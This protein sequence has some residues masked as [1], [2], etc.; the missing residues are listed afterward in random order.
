MLAVS[1]L[2]LNKTLANVASVRLT[3]PL[4]KKSDLKGH[5]ITSVG[6]LA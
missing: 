4:L 1:R 2:C 5:S 6:K 3:M